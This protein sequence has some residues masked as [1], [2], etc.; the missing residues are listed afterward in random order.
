MRT[1]SATAFFLIAY[2]TGIYSQDFGS[3][4][5]FTDT[6]CS[7]GREAVPIPDPDTYHQVFSD[8]SSVKAYNLEC[9]LLIWVDGGD[10]YPLLIHPGD[11]SCYELYGKSRGWRLTC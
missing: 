11:S 9:T 4:D 6:Q 2:A 5:T 7:E 1:F 3:F 10:W 8:Y